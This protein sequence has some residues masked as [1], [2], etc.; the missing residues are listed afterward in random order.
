[1]AFRAAPPP[2]L[3]LQPLH[4][5]RRPGD[6]PR[7]PYRR[8]RVPDRRR[9]AIAAAAG[10]RAHHL[11]LLVP[12]AGQRR[13][14]PDC[15][16]PL[17]PPELPRPGLGVIRRAQRLQRKRPPSERAAAAS[18]P[19]LRPPLLAALVGGRERRRL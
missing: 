17:E 4:A 13:A 14:R 10:N 7:P 9:A 6:R 2:G 12:Q 19:A 16:P 3:H 5:E 8:P 15:G 18:R 1:M 11:F